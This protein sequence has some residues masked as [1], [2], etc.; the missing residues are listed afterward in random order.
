MSVIAKAWSCSSITRN[1]IGTTPDY[2]PRGKI[3]T[4][5]GTWEN[6]R[7]GHGDWN[8]YLDTYMDGQLRE[9]LTNYG[10]IA[11]FDRMWD[12]P[13]ADW[14]L[15]KTYALIQLQPAALIIPK[16]H[17]TPK[18]GE[19][20]QTFEKDLPGQNTAGFNTTYVSHRLPLESGTTLNHSWGFNIGDSNYKKSKKCWY[21]RRWQ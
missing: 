20:V 1:W 12:K 2:Y 15:P 7:S 19:D 13:D 16:H 8:T 14:H 5:E 10:P 11:R 6:G 21:V 17:Q 4:E 18:P 9:L 3:A